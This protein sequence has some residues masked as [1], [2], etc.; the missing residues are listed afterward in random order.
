MKNFIKKPFRTFVIA[1]FM[2]FVL[3]H[4]DSAKEFA[5]LGLNTWFTQIIPSLLPFMILS[6]LL[7]NLDLISCFCRPF[8]FLLRPLFQMSD[9]CLYVL[10]TG[11]LCGF[12]MGAKN[13][14]QLYKEGQLTKA[15]GEYLLA[16]CNNIGPVYFL[17]FV[18]NNV[19]SKALFPYGFLIMFLTPLLYGLLLRHTV[20]R[21]KISCSS[22]M[23][24]KL[25]SYGNS[26]FLDALDTSITTSLVQI[27]V[28]GG[29][30]ILFNLLVLLPA[31]LFQGNPFQSFLH[32]LVEISGGLYALK[33]STFSSMEKFLLAHLALCFN[34]LCCLFQTL[35]FLRDTDLSGQKYMLHKIILCS[36]TLLCILFSIIT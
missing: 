28:L 18:W 32:S 34:G 1:G 13:I 7:I 30:M 27:G 9:V 24:Y 3:F 5:Y 16:F 17:S 21:R 20:Y 36:I 4:A 26:S 31:T 19:Y 23:P 11:F 22:I 15:E 8:R 29:Y 33:A 10:I 35:H 25:E 14:T 6:S 2:F 12:P